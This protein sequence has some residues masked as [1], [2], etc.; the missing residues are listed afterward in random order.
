MAQNHP[1]RTNSTWFKDQQSLH[2]DHLQQSC[3][4]EPTNLDI[5]GTV[6]KIPMTWHRCWPNQ[7]FW[8]ERS[9]SNKPP[10]NNQPQVGNGGIRGTNCWIWELPTVPVLASS[11]PSQ[12]EVAMV[13]DGRS[14][15][16]AALVKGL[17]VV[18]GSRN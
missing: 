11:K 5:S 15:T 9:T 8:A 16:I 2:F 12:C 3:S 7:R 10:P 4:G 13:C 14:V 18:G 17:I 1:L 6:D